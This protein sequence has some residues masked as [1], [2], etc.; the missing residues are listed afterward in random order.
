MK[1]VLL[2]LGLSVLLAG[3]TPPPGVPPPGAPRRIDVEVQPADM[4]FRF[5]PR[6]TIPGMPRVAVAL[7]GGGAR[8]LAHIGVLQRFEEVGFPLDSV[9]GT[10][11]GAL[12]G[13]LYA[14]GFSAKEIEDLFNRLDL[15]RAFLEPLWRNP[16]E[17]LGEQEE[18]SDT[19]LSIERHQ[20][21]LSLA[22]G[23]RSGVEVQHTLQGLLARGAYFSGGDFDRLQRPL[24]ILATNLETGQGRVFGR[25]DL[26]EAVRASM[27]IPGGFRPVIIEGQQYVDGA[28]V[29]NIPVSTAKEAFHPDLVIAVD[30][31]SPLE[32]RPAL[33]ILSVAARSLD[34]V[35]ERRQWES[36][37]AADFVIR[38]DIRGV[39]FLEYGTD[40]AKLVRQGREGFDARREA[41]RELMRSRLSQERLD[42]SQVA[43]ECPGG[44]SPAMAGL[45]A[46]GVKP[47][48]DGILLQDAQIL[49][50]QVLVH[51]LAQEA[52]ATVD[53][54]RVLTIHLRPFPAIRSVEVQAP[55]GWRAAI[56][57][58]VAD[59]VKVGEPFNPQLFGRM[60]GHLV[61][62]FLMEGGPLVDVRGS[63]FEPQTGH[64]LISVDEPF[65]TKVEARSAAGAPVA[66]PHLLR[67][68]GELKGRPF[69]PA[70]LQNRVALAEHRLHLAELRYQLRPDGE[71]G[72][73]ITLVPVPLQ[74]ER[75]DL[76]LG[77]ETTLGS[78]VGL[79]YRAVDLGFRGTELQLSAARNRL[80]ER[81]TLSVGSPFGFS[82]GTGVELVA[83]YWQQRLELPLLWVAPELPGDGLGARISASDLMLR[84]FFRFS[85]LGTGKVSLDLGRRNAAFREDGQR[86]TQNQDAAFLSGEWDN[87]DRHTMPRDGLL[88]R[89][90]F[91]AGHALAGELPGATFQ[92]SYFRA[93]GLTSI[94]EH[95]GFDLDT[96][97]GQGRRLPLDR[98]WVL[99][100][101]SFVIGS[102]SLGFMAP[103]FAAVRFGVP[104]RLYMGLGLTVELTPRFDLAWVAQD[105]ADLLKPEVDFRAQGTGLMLRTTLSN[106]Y[107]ELAYGFLKVRTPQDGGRAVGSFNVLIGTQPF[108]LWKRH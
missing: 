99:G 20:G 14:S 16:G 61:Y 68:L 66:E 24:R 60:M 64:L 32:Q 71:G 28:L 13:A 30:T 36:R 80:Q 53:P 87:F 76:S 11:A 23:L 51:G 31:S 70:D 89:A 49:L 67:L 83:D 46:E 9:T 90:R 96:E 12:V 72:T 73:A 33:S 19:F 42:A 86:R 8:G 58:A 62:R 85:N 78:Q 17:T 38:P 69:R 52:W 45:L 4:V 7:S 81:A 74:R 40:G 10:S 108:D 39:N 44:L 54:G 29:E 35:V 1:P 95:L 37:A 55:D 63:M 2:A 104:L 75:L 79:A 15:T 50:Q 27:S 92:Q 103:N 88:L 91:G 94:G 21:R 5:T 22:Q 107:V 106:F 47:G 6:V 105:P 59:A 82:P 101:P 100:G 3:Q 56:Q 93:R 65:I 34:L 25:G 84:T 18:R 77:Y 57:S 43:F 48:P 97:W 41:L 98:W 26:V 102:R